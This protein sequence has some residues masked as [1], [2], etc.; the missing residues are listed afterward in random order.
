MS[1]D[2][3]ELNAVGGLLRQGQALGI[4]ALTPWKPGDWVASPEQTGNTVE[5][6]GQAQLSQARAVDGRQQTGHPP[7][8][9]CSGQ[10]LQNGAQE[11]GSRGRLFLTTQ[12][13]KISPP[14]MSLI[15]R[16]VLRT[17]EA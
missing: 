5:H 9:H 16:G 12:V 11:W 2:W 17:A 14:R 8:T 15:G 3:P 6:S 13:R 4:H 7:Y 10:S 1:A